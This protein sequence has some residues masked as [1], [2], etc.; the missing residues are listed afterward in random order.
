MYIISGQDRKS[1]GARATGATASLAPL[2]IP[3]NMTQKI[4][5]RTRYLFFD[6]ILAFAGFRPFHQ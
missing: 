5:V 1:G 3:K 6:V 2:Y 4:E